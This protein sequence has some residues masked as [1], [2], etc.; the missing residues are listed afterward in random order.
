[1]ADYYLPAHLYGRVEGILGRPEVNMPGPIEDPE[2]PNLDCLFGMFAN[3]A[4]SA[5][6]YCLTRPGITQTI[7]YCIVDTDAMNA[8]AMRLSVDEYCVAISAELLVRT[9]L[10]GGYFEICSAMKSVFPKDAEPPLIT[11]ENYGNLNHASPFPTEFHDEAFARSHSGIGRGAALALVFHELGHIINGH[12]GLASLGAMAELAVPSVRME[13]LRRLRTL[14][15]DADAF[16]AKEMLRF[17]DGR[18]SQIAQHLCTSADDHL[19]FAAISTLVCFATFTAGQPYDPSWADTRTTHPAA[20]DRL[21]GAAATIFTVIQ[22]GRPESTDEAIAE[23]IVHPS[24]IAVLAS[25]AMVCQYNIE[26]IDAPETLAS[27]D[28]Y[29]DEMRSCW[30]ELR[31]LLMQTKLG[32]HNLAPVQARFARP[33][34]QAV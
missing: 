14:E 25:L 33:A 12:N 26:V 1:M 16:A 32:D 29:S 24:F 8:V 5:I 13:Q 4:E 10:M 18:Q 7:H 27:F 31:P 2:N 11:P 3:T 23:E 22:E 9:W 21:R 15:F 17:F 28:R 30:A 34:F 6:R 20:L 19:R